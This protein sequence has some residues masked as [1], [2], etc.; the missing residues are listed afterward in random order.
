V[1][2]LHKMLKKS[3]VVTS[4]LL[5][6]VFLSIPSVTTALTCPQFCLLL[7]QTNE[8]EARCIEDLCNQINKKLDPRAALD[9]GARREIP[10]PFTFPEKRVKE[11]WEGPAPADI[12]H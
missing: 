5:L 9:L 8:A 6:W 1:P 7:S 12:N 2:T 11:F 4:C 3:T 10:P